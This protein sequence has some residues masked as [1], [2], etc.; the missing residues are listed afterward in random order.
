MLCN[1]CGY[2]GDPLYVHGHVQCSLCKQVIDDCCQ[3]ETCQTETY[4]PWTTKL[5][6]SNIEQRKEETEES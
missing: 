4:S 1:R 5:N 3:G 2:E 6:L